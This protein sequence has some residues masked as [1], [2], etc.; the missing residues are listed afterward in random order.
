MKSHEYAQQLKTA[1]D[2]ILSRP[3]FEME[4]TPGIYLGYY[5]DK[6]PFIALAKALGNV[7]KDYSGTDLKIST[8]VGDI[9][10]WASIPR[11]KVCRKVQEAKWECEPL[12]TPEEEAQITK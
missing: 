10:I 8:K 9:K 12:F 5:W 7:E 3:E 6:T 1:T 4:T 11:D 2:Y